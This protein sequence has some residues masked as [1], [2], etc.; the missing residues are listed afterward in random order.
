M[1]HRRICCFCESWESGGIESFLNNVLLHMDLKGLEVDIMAASIKQSVFTVGLESRGIRFIQ[2][3]GNQRNLIQNHQ[4][5]RKLM[6]KYAYDVVHFNL[7]QGLSWYYVHIAKQEGIPIRIVHSHNTALRKSKT[8]WL[9]LLL[10]HIGVSLYTNDATNLVACSRAAA[11]F[12]FKR[13]V[14]KQNIFQYIP[15]G[16]ELCRFRFSEDKRKTVRA[17]LGLTNSFVVGNI[18]RLCYQKNQMFLLSVLEKLCQKR[19]DAILLLVGNGPDISALKERSIQLRIQSRVLFYG[20]TQKSEDLYCAMDAF[21]FPSH[22]EGL[23]IVAI[24][25]QCNGLPVLSGEKV[26]DE[27]SIT[28]YFYRVPLKMGADVWAKA[29]LEMGRPCNRLEGVTAIEEA[30]FSIQTVANTISQ[31]YWETKETGEE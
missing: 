25:A 7:F 9:K 21:V 5:F 4:I 17:E 27:T 28:P 26:P 30:G 19:L 3:S 29:L 23:G 24:E 22:F 10:H 14:I 31:L 8:R 12:M 15:N 20:T 18:G 11:K 13:K 6:K 1:E 2:L 16:I